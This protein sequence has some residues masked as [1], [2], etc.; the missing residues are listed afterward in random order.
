M[1][2]KYGEKIRVKKNPDKI[3]IIHGSIAIYSL[4]VTGIILL[5][6]MMFLLSAG[7]TGSPGHGIHATG[8]TLMMVELTDVRTGAVFSLASFPDRPSP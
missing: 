1:V 7:C 8:D 5:L 6:L 3:R 2:L 4:V